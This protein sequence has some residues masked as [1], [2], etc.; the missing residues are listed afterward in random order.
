MSFP[1]TS[2]E[3]LSPK[4]QFVL[5]LLILNKNKQKL[6]FAPTEDKIRLTTPVAPPGE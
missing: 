5:L 4:K 6:Q 3:E 1:L 2:P